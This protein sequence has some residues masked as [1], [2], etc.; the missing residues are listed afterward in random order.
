MAAVK[1]TNDPIA[2]ELIKLLGCPK[3]V[4]RIEYSTGVNEVTTVTVEYF[5]EIDKDAEETLAPII[6]RFRLEQITE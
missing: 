1:G 3:N 5:P 4:R 6:K 2:M